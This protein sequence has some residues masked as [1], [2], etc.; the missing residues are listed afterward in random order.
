MAVVCAP[1]QE[2]G[3]YDLANL[4]VNGSSFNSRYLGK[5]ASSSGYK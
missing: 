4:T 2:L 5:I 3:Y 1:A